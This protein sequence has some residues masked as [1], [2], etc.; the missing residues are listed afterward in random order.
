MKIAE[1]FTSLRRRWTRR[2]I[3]LGIWTFVGC[4]FGLQGYLQG[5]R[6]GKRLPLLS[7]LSWYLLLSYKLFIVSPLIFAEAR[8]WPLE[9]G[10]ILRH[11]PIHLGLIVGFHFVS[12]PLITALHYWLGVPPL[13][14]TY[15]N[16]ADYTIVEIWH[17]Y[18]ILLNFFFYW[19]TLI[20]GWSLDYQ[21]RFREG[22]MKAAVLAAQLAEAQL[23]ALKMQLQPHFLF[24]TLNSISALLHQDPEAA[25]KM[26]ARLGNFLRL[27]LENGGE[28]LTTLRRELEFLQLYLD[29]ERVR[30]KDRLQVN[31]E[32][33]NDGPGLLNSR[34][35]NLILQ[36]LAENAIRHGIAKQYAPGQITVRAH[37]RGGRL[38]VEIADNGPGIAARNGA[39]PAFK[40]GVGL[41]NTRA[42][43][44]QLYGDTYLLAFKNNEPRGLIVTLAIPLA[45]QIEDSSDEHE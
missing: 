2:L 12:T 41:S 38:Q 22:E 7:P 33:Q 24:N 5:L 28:Q 17:P 18:T 19:V 4:S 16:L 37:I 36:P 20:V 32:M 42:R 1:T 6:L 14:G 8:R 23:Q 45:Y 29:I 15:A 39:A 30:F 13:G 11:L 9:R 34:I 10:K 3:A 40:D 21:R 35:P 43:L 44:K 25:D 27:T 31:I 26:V